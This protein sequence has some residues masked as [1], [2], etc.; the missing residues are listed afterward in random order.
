VSYYLSTRVS[1][2]FQDTI[3]KVKEALKAEGFGVLTE[4]DVKATLREKL[5]VQF[6]DY[7]ILGACNPGYAHRAL[8]AEPRVGV[9]LPCNVVVQ[10]TASGQVEV[11]AMDPVAAMQAVDNPD[12]AQIAA[13]VKEKLQRAIEKL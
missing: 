6:P 5:D 11:S 3:P 13:E 12:L 8:R 7:V 10:E 4:I 9:M 1:G 2:S